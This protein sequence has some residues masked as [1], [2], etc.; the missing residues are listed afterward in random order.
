MTSTSGPGPI[1]SDA[2]TPM[3]RM[4]PRSRDEAHRAATPLELFFDLCFVVAVAQA[5]VQLVHA[6][7]EGHPGAGVIGYGYVFF[8]V[9]WAWMNF[10]WF[11]SAYDVD[12][13]PYRIATLVQIAGVLVYAAGVPRAFNDNDWTIAVIGY[14]I[15]RVA[16]TT[17]WL[18]AAAAEEGPAR[19]TAFKYT[20]S[21]VVCQ[22]AWVGL[23]FVPEGAKR[24][25]FIVVAAAELLIP[26]V[27][28]RSQQ[29]P[30]HPHHIVERYGL[31][32][33][34]VLG[35]TM[36]A[37]TIAVQSALNENEALGELLPI[38]GGGL[39]IIFSAWWIYFAVPA[40]ERLV[41][42]RQAIPWGYGHVLIFGSAAAI[43]AGIEV[44]IEHVMGKAHISAF[45]ANAAVTVPVALFLFTVWLLH[46]RYF[47][48]TLP[49]QL[50]VPV[51][52]L[53]VLA[54][55]YAG[56]WAVLATGLVTAA[57]VAVGVMLAARPTAA[58]GAT[59]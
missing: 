30:W 15:M 17:Q 10:T 21:L 55:T 20:A 49:Q 38:A 58:R 3:R 48:R 28:E 46:E 19:R 7:A 45:A 37:S 43:G 54:C 59:A 40:H 57:T 32:T 18:R 56:D 29:T 26:L 51:A 31:F 8:G 1:G 4:T 9:W 13:V 35:E 11:A 42:N 39:L 16:L 50:T 14:L 24:W 22:L 27:A 6:L 5:G 41:S 44:S 34:I 23:L 25:L 52:T 12:D 33:I 53:A 36:F 2:S 47:E